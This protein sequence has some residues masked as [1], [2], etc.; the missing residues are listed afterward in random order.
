MKI[1]FKPRVK[2]VTSHHL[3]IYVPENTSFCLN[4]QAMYVF[5]RAKLSRGKEQHP[6]CL[7]QIFEKDDLAWRLGVEISAFSSNGQAISF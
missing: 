3:H 5:V 4:P 2:Y 7:V 1:T 6:Q